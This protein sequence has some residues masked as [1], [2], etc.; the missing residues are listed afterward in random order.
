[1]L[2]VSILKNGTFIEIKKGEVQQ[3]SNIQQILKTGELEQEQVNN[4]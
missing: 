4:L 3:V 1:M 2:R